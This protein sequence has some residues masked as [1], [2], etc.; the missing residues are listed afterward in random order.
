MLKLI[1]FNWSWTFVALLLCH[2]CQGYVRVAPGPRIINGTRD[3]GQQPRQGCQVAGGREA[4]AAALELPPPFA[5][6]IPSHMHNIYSLYTA[7][8][9]HIYR[10]TKKRLPIFSAHAL[11]LSSTLSSL[12]LSIL[13]LPSPTSFLPF[14]SYF[15]FSLPRSG[16]PTGA[17]AWMVATLQ[18]VPLTF[19]LII[20][21]EIS[22]SDVWQLCAHLIVI[23]YAYFRNQKSHGKIKIL[24]KFN[25][26]ME[27]QLQVSPKHK[28]WCGSTLN[29]DNFYATLQLDF[30]KY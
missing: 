5:H 29:Y 21:C 17:V 18:Q 13:P 20:C 8:I 19:V 25:E 2:S 14:T 4:T 3:G 6:L 15:L 22:D 27:K 9:S 26:I 11:S 28:E 16:H 1:Y 7:Y 23:W 24:L 12:S 30:Q 10:I